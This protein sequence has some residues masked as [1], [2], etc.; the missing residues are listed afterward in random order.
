MKK[1]VIRKLQKDFEDFAY[2]IDGMEYWYARD[3]QDLLGYKSWKKFFEV[4]KKSITSCKSSE[5]DPKDHFAR[6]DKMV[7]IG[8]GAIRNIGDIILTRYACYLIAQNG[9]PKKMQIA[10]AQCYFAVQTRKQEILEE[11]IALHE[12]LKARVKLS[13]S[14]KKLSGI[15]YERDVDDWGFARIRSKGDK[16]LFGGY[17]TLEMKKKLNALKL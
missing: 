17:A 10:F 16:A 13:E 9:D 8:S 14:E 2:I 15:L 6:V 11:R 5:Q 4:I 3:L 12:R 1:E 7:K